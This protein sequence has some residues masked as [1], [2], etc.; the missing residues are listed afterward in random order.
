MAWTKAVKYI[1]KT[2]FSSAIICLG[3]A[4]NKRVMRNNI[5]LWTEQ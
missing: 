3:I 2:K 5:L 4:N 1:S